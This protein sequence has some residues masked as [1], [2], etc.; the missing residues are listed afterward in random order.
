MNVNNYLITLFLIIMVNYSCQLK[1]HKETK[2]YQTSKKIKHNM[3]F[4]AAIYGVCKIDKLSTK[5][6]PFQKINNIE[7]TNS[8]SGTCFFITKE[9]FITCNHVYN[10]NLSFS[11]YVSLFNGNIIHNN[12][13]IIYENKDYD[14][15][16]GRTTTPVEE[17]LEFE[18]PFHEVSGIKGKFYGYPFEKNKIVKGSINVLPTQV[19]LLDILSYPELV[20][21]KIERSQLIKTP[22]IAGL[23][24][25]NNCNVFIINPEASLGYSGGP[26]I[27]ESGKIIGLQSMGVDTKINGVMEKCSVVIDIRDKVIN[28]LITQNK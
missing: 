19:E 16:I 23:N 25:I 7:L 1:D 18:K 6:L 21:G 27:S 15:T 14:L 9:I 2:P 24:I 17:Y 5:N 22:L 11:N 10:S 20:E 13:E 26:F 28:Y 12:I 3:N 4:K 8:I